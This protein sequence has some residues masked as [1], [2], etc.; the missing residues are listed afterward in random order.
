MCVQRFAL[1]PWDVL[2][3]VAVGMSSISHVH[4]THAL[5]AAAFVRSVHPGGWPAMVDKLLNGL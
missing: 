4:L 5:P 2:L 1:R 3:S